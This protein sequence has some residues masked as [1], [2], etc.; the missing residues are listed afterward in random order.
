MALGVRTGWQATHIRLILTIL[1]FPA[2]PLFTVHKPLSSFSFSPISPSHTVS[3]EWRLPTFWVSFTLLC[4]MAVSMPGMYLTFKN[5][6]FY[7]EEIM[8]G[9]RI[10]M[11]QIIIQRQNK[12]N[13]GT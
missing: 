7:V 11:A 13:Q 1:V 12:F 10:A 4:H 9:G 2:A 8:E 6:F 3:S 5:V